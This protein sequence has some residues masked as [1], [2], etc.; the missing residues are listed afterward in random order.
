MPMRRVLNLL[1]VASLVVFVA[2]TAIV[3]SDAR[4]EFSRVYTKET[5][6]PAIPMAHF[7]LQANL[8]SRFADKMQ[9]VWIV[10]LPLLGGLILARLFVPRLIEGRRPHYA[11]IDNDVY[12]QPKRPTPIRRRR[13]MPEEDGNAWSEP[14]LTTEAQRTLDP[15]DL[16]TPTPHG[17]VSR[18]SHIGQTPFVRR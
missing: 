3:Y 8:Q 7:K 14:S 10:M 13:L 11:A 5:V 12:H 16:Y 9:P 17:T 2:W 4:Q 15:R 18:M 1:I 6:E